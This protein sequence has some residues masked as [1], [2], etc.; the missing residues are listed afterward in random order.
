MKPIPHEILRKLD[1]NT[2]ALGLLC[3]VEYALKQNGGEKLFVD[4]VLPIRIRIERQQ[5]ELLAVV[6]KAYA[7]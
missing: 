4:H 6:D 2:H 7:A 1:D 5:R 3:E